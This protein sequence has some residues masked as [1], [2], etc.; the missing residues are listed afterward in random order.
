MAILVYCYFLNI[1]K[2]VVVV[3]Y[4]CKKFLYRFQIHKMFIS[5]SLCRL[6]LLTFICTVGISET[7]IFSHVGANFHPIN[8]AAE[9]LILSLWQFDSSLFSRLGDPYQATQFARALV[10]NDR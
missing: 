3:Q 4:I 9:E 10:I 2:Y 7:W 6:F 5:D 1:I 8:V